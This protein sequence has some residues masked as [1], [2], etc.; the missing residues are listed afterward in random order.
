MPRGG[1]ETVHQSAITFGNERSSEAD[2]LT[3]C[4]RS[5]LARAGLLNVKQLI[6][7][8][9]EASAAPLVRL[10]EPLVEA[11]I[12]DSPA[13]SALV[14]ANF[15][16]MPIKSLAVEFPTRAPIGTVKSFAH[17]ELPVAT[18]PAPSPWKEEG[19]T[20]LHRFALPLGDD[21][22]VLVLPQSD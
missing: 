9:A 11:G 3:P 8:V 19:Y 12:Y 18:L 1:A 17:G 2:A 7:D 5:T 10:S 13:G 4:C 6:W 21:D 16:Y 20:H 14:L 22:V 15:T